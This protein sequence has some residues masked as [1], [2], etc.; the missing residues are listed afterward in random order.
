MEELPLERHLFSDRKM[1]E[2]T[3]SEDKI[4]KSVYEEEKDLKTFTQTSCQKVGSKA[5]QGAKLCS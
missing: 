1:E 4:T 2:K 5:I 3:V